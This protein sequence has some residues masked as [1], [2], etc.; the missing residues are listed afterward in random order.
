[1][2]RENSVMQVNVSE[3]IEALPIDEGVLQAERGEL[4]DRAQARREIQA[5]KDSWRKQRSLQR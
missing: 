4:I 2:K 5:M 1:M 3:D